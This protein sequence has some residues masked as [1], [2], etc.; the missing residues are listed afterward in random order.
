ML[1]DDEWMKLNKQNFL[2]ICVYEVKDHVV[3][4]K[5]RM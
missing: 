1:S 2:V 5:V 4:L 3:S